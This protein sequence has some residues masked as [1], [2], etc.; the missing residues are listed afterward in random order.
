MISRVSQT[1]VGTAISEPSNSSSLVNVMESKSQCEANLKTAQPCSYPPTYIAGKNQKPDYSVDNL[2]FGNV[3]LYEQ[4]ALF[5]DNYEDL[6]SY[7][8][9]TGVIHYVGSSDYSSATSSMA[10]NAQGMIYIISYCSTNQGGS[11]I[12]S[13]NATLGVANLKDD[14]V[15]S[16]LFASFPTHLD[17]II[18]DNEYNVYVFDNTTVYT[19]SHTGNI[20][21]IYS[22]LNVNEADIV[23]G[24]QASHYKLHAVNT[25]SIYSAAVYYDLERQSTTIFYASNGVGGL[26][27]L[28]KYGNTTLTLIFDVSGYNII[29]PIMA[30]SAD[31]VYSSA[32]P[33][34][35]N[36]QLFNFHDIFGYQVFTNLD[37]PVGDR[38]RGL[39]V[40]ASGDRLLTTSSTAQ[41]KF[42]TTGVY[43]GYT[44]TVT[45]QAVLQQSSFAGAWFTCGD[46]VK[47]PVPQSSPEYG[48]KCAN[49]GFVGNICVST[50]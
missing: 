41:S 31:N 8:F 40:S 16:Q 1:T 14:R 37:F 24:P 30:G 19:L 17:G 46:E 44:S 48:A 2:C 36:V 42:V 13:L 43:M 6:Y 5:L 47:S 22:V 23:L 18:N 35:G 10:V 26:S 9:T 12:V 4:Y 7:D 32:N 3:A 28:Y 21:P 39:A 38:Y 34:F 20:V 15:V 50:F 25:T 33:D 27:E 45:S 11:C 29:A 49:N